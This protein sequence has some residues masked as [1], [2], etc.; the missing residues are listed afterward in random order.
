[1]GI[2]VIV[3]AVILLL[4][5]STLRYRM[6]KTRCTGTMD[7]LKAFIKFPNDVT[8]KAEVMVGIGQLSA[9]FWIIAGVALS[10]KGLQASLQ[11]AASPT[12]VKLGIL[13]L[14][15]LVF[16]MLVAGIALKEQ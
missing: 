3:L 15:L 14:P 11:T 6:V 1:M 7:C 4:V 10:S 8:N 16:M 13:G 2:I 12:S 5:L 9:V